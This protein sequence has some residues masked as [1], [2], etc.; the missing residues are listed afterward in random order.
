MVTLFLMQKLGKRWETCLSFPVP[1]FSYSFMSFVFFFFFWD[2][3][4]MH[5]AETWQPCLMNTI[6]QM[7]VKTTQIELLYAGYSPLPIIEFLWK[8][9]RSYPK[10][11]HKILK[12][13]H[14]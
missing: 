14:S 5:F 6:K 12:Y 11:S 1:K 7:Y 3:V 13:N 4:G 2:A 10:Y 9:T 8:V